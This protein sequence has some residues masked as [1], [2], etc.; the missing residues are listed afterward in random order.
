MKDLLITISSNV[1]ELQISDELGFKR[2]DLKSLYKIVSS[3]FHP[4]LD[5]EF[6]LSILEIFFNG[7]CF[8]TDV[9]VYNPTA[10]LKFFDACL[11]PNNTFLSSIKQLENKVLTEKKTLNSLSKLL[12]LIHEPLDIFDNLANIVSKLK[13][14]KSLFLKILQLELANESVLEVEPHFLNKKLSIE[15]FLLKDNQ[16]KLLLSLLYH[17]CLITLHHEEKKLDEK[18]L[19]KIPNKLIQH[20]MRHRLRIEWAKSKSL[21][22]FLD[23]ASAPTAEKLKP[24]FTTFLSEV[25]IDWN[26]LNETSVQGFIESFF[27]SFTLVETQATVISFEKKIQPKMGNH[28]NGSDV[29]VEVDTH[30]IVIELKKLTKWDFEKKGQIPSN[31]PTRKKMD[32]RSFMIKMGQLRHDQ[33]L[34]RQLAMSRSRQ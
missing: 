16:N 19:I 10:C 17:S 13:N 3:R 6:V 11:V 29:W 26:V 31:Y 2:E 27:L 9:K 12:Q 7:Y 30:E 28:S 23:F 14:A 21:R 18:L 25:K 8:G 15:D 34:A 22:L 1:W 5:E 4:K 24:F 33:N 32:T 20:S